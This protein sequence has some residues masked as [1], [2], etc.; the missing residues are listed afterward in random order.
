MTLEKRK[1]RLTGEE[2]QPKRY[3]QWF[4]RPANRIKFHNDQA[5]LVRQERRVHDTALGKNLRI[6]KELLKGK[7]EVRLSKEFLRGKGFSFEDFSNMAKYGEFHVFAIYGYIWMH[8]LDDKKAP[9]GFIKLIK[10]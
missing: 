4:A 9:T 7:S 8:E 2:F 6:I 5:G 1:D 10:P 3:T